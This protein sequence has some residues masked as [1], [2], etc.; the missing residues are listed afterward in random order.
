MYRA[1]VDEIAFTLKHVAG[2]QEALDAEQL[3]DLSGD[4]VDAILTEAGRFASEEIAPLSGEGEKG[5]PLADAVVTT[6]AGWAGLYRN[7]IAGGWNSLTGAPDYGGQGLPTMLSVAANEMWNA[8]CMAFSLCSL[9]TMGAVEAIEAHA[10]EALKDMYLAKLISGEW[11]GTMNLTEPHAGSDLGVLKTRAERA[12]DGSYRIFGQK[13]YITYGE[14][15]FSDNIVHLVLARLPDAPPGTRGISLFLVP[16]F[17]PDEDGNPGVRNDLFCHSV[18]H[19]LGIHGS[20]T[21]TMIYGDGRFG[22]TPGAV[23]WL[24]GEENRGLACMFTMMNNARLNVGIQGVAV[25]DAAYQKALDYANERT[26]GKAPGWQGKGMSPII[27]H[28]DIQRSLV[29]MKSL[30]QASRAISYCCAHAIDMANS[31][32]QRGAEEETVFWRERAN[33]LTPIAKAFSTDIG[34]EAASMGVQIHGGMGFIEETGAARLLRDARIAPI[35]E[36]TNGI[37]A[38]DLV[39]RKLPQSGGEHVKG[40]IAELKEVAAEVSGK[41][42]PDFGMTADRLDAALEDLEAATNW[43]LQA[44]QDGRVKAALAGATPYLRLFGLASGTVYLAKGALVETVEGNAARIAL[45]RFCAE[46]LLAETSAL[47]EAVTEG[48]YSLE[49]ARSALG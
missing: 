13:I 33:L 6:P 29:T 32:Q 23:G 19:K 4:L 22:D 37:Q 46:N 39:T 15:D 35:Y 38:I 20:P 16:K 34:V 45:C 47:K 7:W 42:N 36:G 12:G 49:Q 31:A 40:Y 17:I 28:P 43:L 5:T 9:L 10:D 14:H 2:L 41:N 1:P 25:A 18:E 21:C 48:A 26:Q 44:L 30:T 24:V 27:E 11:T 8:S 3:G